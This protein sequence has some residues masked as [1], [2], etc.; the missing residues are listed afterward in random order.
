MINPTVAELLEGHTSLELECIDR[1][2]LNGYVPSLQTGAG[3]NSFVKRQMG[4]TVASTCLV[5]PMTAA[6]VAS[7]ESYVAEHDVP[8]VTF[9]KGERKDDVAKRYLAEFKGDEGVLF[10]GKAQEKANVFRTTKRVNAAG[11]KYAWVIR[12]TAMVNHYYFYIVDRDFGPLFIK[13]CS[14]FPYPVKVCLN[15]NEWLKRQLARRGIEHEALDNGLARCANAQ[16]AQRLADQLDEAKI[17]AV[18]RKWLGRLPHP[19]AANYRAAGYRYDLSILQAEF[20]LTQVLDKPVTGR[21]FFE[22]VIR[23]HLDLGRPDR[24]QLIFGRRVT[25]RTPGVFRTRV[26]TQGV[27]PSL[28]IFYKHS[29]IKQYHKEGRALRTETTI[30]DTY[31]FDV[32]RRLSNLPALRRIGFDANRRLL[33]AQTLS[34]DPTIGETCFETAVRPAQIGTQRASGLPFGDPR[35]MALLQ[36]LTRFTTEILGFRHRDFREAVAQLLG[37][38]A[39]RYGPGQM[40]YD[41]RRLRLHGL[42]ERVPG[43]HRYRVTA[44][45]ALTAI[46]FVRTYNRALRPALSLPTQIPPTRHNRSA[47]AALDGL[48]AAIDRF[49]VEAQLVAA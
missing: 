46:L 36:A 29:K 23:E 21:L 30:N 20:S 35:S 44:N 10:V 11:H 2:Y 17:E 24:V 15:G 14:Y 18:F 41:L 13:F 8:V 45:G 7:I 9:L 4:A 16:Q 40:T 34:H 26:I 49:L 48:H 1:M 39:A 22:Q 32:G 43:T 25:R 47:I 37:F 6:F 38:P 3:F 42:I 33:R 19:F 31:D 5:A 27:T 12:T 28:H